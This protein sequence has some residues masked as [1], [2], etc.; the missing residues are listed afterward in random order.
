[1]ARYSE[2]LI[3]YVHKTP[4]AVPEIAL[5][6]LEM[7]MVLVVQG[8]MSRDGQSSGSTRAEITHLLFRRVHQNGHIHK[9]DPRRSIAM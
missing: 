7:E 8:H 1:M 9:L 4:S 2:E 3:S 5:L 6:T